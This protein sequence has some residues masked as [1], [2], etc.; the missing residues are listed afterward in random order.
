MKRLHHVF[1][2]GSG[3]LGV[4]FLSAAVYAPAI[5]LSPVIP[6]P[7][8]EITP[9]PPQ[10]SLKP[11]AAKKERWAQKLEM[12]FRTDRVLSASA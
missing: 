2:I 1:A 6:A 11:Q 5:P 12:R 9:L 8:I 10:I 4:L 3:L 7:R